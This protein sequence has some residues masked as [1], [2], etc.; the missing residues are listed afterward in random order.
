MNEI[1]GKL[2]ARGLNPYFGFMHRDKEK[3][4][5]LASDFM[6]EW[7]A[8]IVDTLVIGMI[9]GNEIHKNQFYR[10]TD[11][12]GCF[13]TKEGL[14]TYIGKLKKRLQT[15]VKYLSTVEYPVSFRRAMDLQISSLIEAMTNK[16][17]GIYC[18]VEI[19]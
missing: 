10:D 5:T 2:E 16:D 3:H 4:P 1:Y 19:R 15:E 8:T 6:E 9:N 11:E 14:K 13:I 18:P 12:P 7:R 17:A